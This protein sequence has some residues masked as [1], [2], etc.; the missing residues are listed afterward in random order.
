MA[1]ERGGLGVIEDSLVRDVDVKDDAHD[2]GGLAGAQ[3]E[4][5]Q[6]REDEAQDVGRVV[7]FAD[8]NGGFER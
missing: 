6:K 8:V 7:N 2:V 1:V 4:G 5:D 3:G